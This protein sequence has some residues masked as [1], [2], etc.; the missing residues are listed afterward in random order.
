MNEMR[1]HGD[2]CNVEVH[3]K[4]GKVFQAHRLVLA[5]CSPYFQAMFRTDLIERRSG[6]VHLELEDT[7]VIEHLID[8]CY[9]SKIDITAENVQ[10]ILPTADLLQMNQVKAACCDYMSY[11]LDSSNCLGVWM[12]AE[13]HLC[14]KLA[15]KASIYAREKFVDVVRR[16][17]FLELPLD[18]L[19]WLTKHP[20]LNI[21]CEDQVCEAVLRW[22]GQEPKTRTC[23]LVDLLQDIRLQLMHPDYVMSVLYQH[24]LV[25]SDEPSAAYLREY[26]L[27][28][29]SN[30]KQMTL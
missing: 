6:I 20:E 18:R 3:T 30:G 26:V 21:G 12:F 14:D 9:T 5:A 23:H 27:G 25:R 29:T 28:G 17:E 7:D 22:V 1:K 19:Q 2:L 4:G 10:R 16:D 11:H 15:L 8:F 13:Q 24:P